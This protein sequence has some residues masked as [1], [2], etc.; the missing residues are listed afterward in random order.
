MTE[1][2]AYNFSFKTGAWGSVILAT[3]AYF[4]NTLLALSLLTVWCLVI[5]FALPWVYVFY[6][7]KVGY[8]PQWALRGPHQ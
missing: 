2:N 3:Y 1:R 4:G 6:M 7:D 8:I 5:L